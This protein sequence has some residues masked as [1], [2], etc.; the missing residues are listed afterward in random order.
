MYCISTNKIHLTE[1]FRKFISLPCYIFIHIRIF[2]F[3]IV[4][5]IYT[6]SFIS[7][8]F[9]DLYIWVQ[10]KAG[11]ICLIINYFCLFLSLQFNFIIMTVCVVC[12]LFL[13]DFM[14]RSPI[15]CLHTRENK[16]CVCAYI[17]IVKSICGKQKY[18]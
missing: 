17:V 4:I 5:S 8:I 7:H 11:K 3:F 13:V 14:V 1:D 15:L 12:V 10:R 16:S 18:Q 9:L 6:I 2:I